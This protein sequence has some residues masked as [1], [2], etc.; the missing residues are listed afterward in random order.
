M[1]EG[2]MGSSSIRTP[3]AIAPEVTTTT[4][5]PE[6]CSAATSSAMRATTESRRSPLSC[7]TIDEPSLTTATGMARRT[8][9]RRAG[10]QLE[11]HAA[12]LDVVAGLESLR[13][14]RRDDAHAPQP[15]LDVGQRLLVLEVVPGDQALDRL[16]RDAELA[17]A[18]A[19]HLE[20]LA[21]RRAEDLDLRHAVLARHLGIR[22]PGLLDGHAPQ[23]L[24]GELVEALARG[25]RGHEHRHALQALAPLAGR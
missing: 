2:R 17:P 7:A 1:A 3:R 22:G 13:L 24:A 12:D 21:R 15:V 25:A 9:E 10:I 11:D 5:T 8:L 18:E 20:G 16:P 14:E 19:L 6:R 4:S 23:Q